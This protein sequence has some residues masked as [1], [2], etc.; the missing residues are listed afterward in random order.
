MVRKEFDDG[1]SKKLFIFENETLKDYNKW[2]RFEN[3]IEILY[4]ITD[5][6]V[7]EAGAT[8]EISNNTKVLLVNANDKN[9]LFGQLIFNVGSKLCARNIIS[10]AIYNE[11]SINPNT[12]PPNNGGWC[13]F[14]NKCKSNKSSEYEIQNFI[15][16][17]LGSEVW[18]AI[19]FYDMTADNLGRCDLVELSNCRYNIYLENSTINIKILRIKRVYEKIQSNNINGFSIDQNSDLQVT[20]RLNVDVNN[21]FSSLDGKVEITTGS[22]IKIKAEKVNLGIKLDSRDEDIKSKVYKSTDTINIFKNDENRST[23]VVRFYNDKTPVNNNVP[24]P[25]DDIEPE[26]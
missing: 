22:V 6:L 7:I 21:L 12:N 11:K 15:G 24:E 13:F 26:A 23:G 18:D 3:N 14:G 1:I 10:Y 4:I 2:E 8:L 17:Y 9:K 19:S 16:A 25:I 20:N 5:K